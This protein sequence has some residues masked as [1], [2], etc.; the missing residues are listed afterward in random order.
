MLVIEELQGT[1]IPMGRA[2]LQKPLQTLRQRCSRE[3]AELPVIVGV[4]GVYGVGVNCG[5][6]RWW[7]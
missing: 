2:W 3:I 1:C 7:W 4:V 5:G 6:S